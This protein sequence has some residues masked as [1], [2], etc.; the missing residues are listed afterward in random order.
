[1]VQMEMG[2]DD[3]VNVVG[4]CAIGVA[5][6]GDIVQSGASHVR[7]IGKASVVVVAHVHAAIQHDVLPADLHQQTRTTHI[8]T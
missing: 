2:N 8:L 4:E 3:G 6:S 7:E 1:M 5:G